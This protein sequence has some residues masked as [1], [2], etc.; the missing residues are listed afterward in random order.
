MP[1][2][3]TEWIEGNRLHSYIE[4]APLSPAEAANL[5]GLA[6]E[7]CQLL[8]EML[9]EEAIWVETSLEAIVVGSEESHRGFTFWISPLKWLGQN[10]GQQGLEAIIILTEQVLGW[11]EQGISD[12]AGMGLGA[13]LNWLRVSVKTASI[14]EAREMLAQSFGNKAPA[15]TEYLAGQANRPVIIRRNKRSSALFHFIIGTVILLVVAGGV[16]A[17]IQRHKLDNSKPPVVSAKST[18]TPAPPNI[19]EKEGASVAPKSNNPPKRASV[20]KK[21]KEQAKPVPSEK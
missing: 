17:F 20:K 18:P 2:I 16:W 11:E 8:S 1:F 4:N 14:Q 7:V 19:A 6:L 5:L 10:E 13:W 9:E 3:A 15:P 21:H 12:E